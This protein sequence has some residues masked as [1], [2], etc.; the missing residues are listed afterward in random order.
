M[1]EAEL[2]QRRLNVLF[3]YLDTNN[4]D[5]SQAYDRICCIDSIYRSWASD[6][7]SKASKPKE[8]QVSFYDAVNTGLGVY[9]VSMLLQDFN[10]IIKNEEIL[11]EAEKKLSDDVHNANRICSAISCI[12]INR[13]YRE[14]N[15]VGR[16]GADQLNQ[17][18]GVDYG[19]NG[20]DDPESVMNEVNIGEI[21]DTIHI[22]LFHTIRITPSEIT[23]KEE[24]LKIQQDKSDSGAVVDIDDGLYD[25]YSH[26][27][28]SILKIKSKAARFDRGDR[29]RYGSGGNNKFMTVANTEGIAGGITESD[30]RN[31]HQDDNKIEL[32][33]YQQAVYN[34]DALSLQLQR[35][36][37]KKEEDATTSSK[38]DH[39]VMLDAVFEEVECEMI[40]D[41]AESKDASKSELICNAFIGFILDEEFDSDAFCLDFVKNGTGLS[42]NII[43]HLKSEFFGVGS[44]RAMERLLSICNSMAYHVNIFSN[45]YQ[46]GF[47]YF[48]WR[49]YRNLNLKENLVEDIFDE[50]ND[51]YMLSEWYIQAKWADLKEE[52]INNTI[53]PYSIKEFQLTMNKAQM[54]LE[55]FQADSDNKSLSAVIDWKRE[56]GIS[57]GD[58]PK[59]EHICALM[60]YTNYT[61]NCTAFSSTYRR[62][63][64][65]ETDRKLKERHAQVANQGRLLRELIEAFGQSMKGMY[66]SA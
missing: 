10:Y 3:T 48:Y 56:Y 19:V 35:E 50:W 44:I 38:V 7:P 59:A 49:F 6:R 41:G 34:N 12:S 24:E 33:I 32:A 62:R 13:N 61:K 60:M 36:T 14:R 20:N 39:E 9:N 17:L 52:A 5:K 46:P 65:Y 54:K 53:A 23:K 22:E 18:Y 45:E 47:R 43:T 42:S 1:K 15:I 16:D 58:E 25:R 29:D 40:S 63:T 51:G 21:M 27:V 4:S 26:A 37:D 66:P 2:L 28:S 31:G 57:E 64:G 55:A 8:R 11:M 30:A